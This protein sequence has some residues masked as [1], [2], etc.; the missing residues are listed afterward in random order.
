[1]RQVLG[2]TQAATKA[3]LRKYLGI[4]ERGSAADSAANTSM[5]LETKEE[6]AL[7]IEVPAAAAAPGAA[8]DQ[9]V[10]RSRRRAEVEVAEEAEAGEREERRSKRRRKSSEVKGLQV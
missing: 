2:R 5:V 3:A 10:R 7:V 1:M 6:A 8:G 9:G 4:K